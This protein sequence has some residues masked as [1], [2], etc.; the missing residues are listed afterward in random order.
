M[1]TG[2]RP[3]ATGDTGSSDPIPTP[4]V[5]HWRRFRFS[6]FHTIGF[7]VVCCGIGITWQQMTRPLTFPG[8]AEVV[9]SSITSP[10][11]GLL[12]NVSVTSF[13]S[14]STGQCLGEVVPVDSHS[15]KVMPVVA[16]TCG[17]VTA[18]H[19]QPGERVLAGQPL[20]TITAHETRRVL[21]FIPPNFPVIPEVGA[22]VEVRTRTRGKKKGTAQV[23][24]VGPQWESITNA[25][26]FSAS[27]RSSPAQMI[28][29]PVAISL[30]A[31]LQLVPGEPVDITILR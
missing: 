26:A 31:D 3:S 29:R 25:F 27:A 24:G 21:G 4:F 12:T 22:K 18:V 16:P 20:V 7:L 13:Q 30:P 9:Q 23:V 6:F 19:H 14:V 28:G 15:G 10:G 2:E 11:S 8:Q 1:K 5:E 17:V